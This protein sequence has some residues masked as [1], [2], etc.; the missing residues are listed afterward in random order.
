MDINNQSFLADKYKKQKSIRR[1]IKKII[2]RKYNIGW[3]SSY[4]ENIIKDL[5]ATL[6]ADELTIEKESDDCYV[7]IW[8]GQR[9]FA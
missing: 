3:A 7:I 4:K 6:F 1:E 5:Q 9:Y 2:H 8:R